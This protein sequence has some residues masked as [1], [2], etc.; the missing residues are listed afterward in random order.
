MEPSTPTLITLI[1]IDREGRERKVDAP[2]GSNLRDVLL[3][4]DF[5]PYTPLTRQL[6]CG[7]RGLCATCG[8]WIEAGEPEPVHWHDRWARKF[9]YPRLS[10][11]IRVDAP[12]TVRQVDKWVWGNSRKWNL[13]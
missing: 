2:Q 3:A 10:C 12:M 6:N 8:V 13:G 5:S 7:G 11:Q 1:L 9:G 4:Y